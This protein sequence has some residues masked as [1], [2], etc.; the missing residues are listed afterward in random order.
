MLK[1]Q[2]KKK[3]LNWIFEILTIFFFQPKI[4]LQ[5]GLFLIFMYFVIILEKFTIMYF[6]IILEKFT[7]KLRHRQLRL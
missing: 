6:A 1:A 7:T 3:K 4:Y 5:M 2:K